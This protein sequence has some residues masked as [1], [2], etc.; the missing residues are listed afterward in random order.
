MYGDRKSFGVFFC[1]RQIL[2]HNTL[3]QH[4]LCNTKNTNTMISSSRRLPVASIFQMCAIAVHPNLDLNLCNTS[5]Q[6][7]YL[8]LMYSLFYLLLFCRPLTGALTDK[9]HVFIEYLC[10]FFCH[11]I[12]STHT[13]P[14]YLSM[15]FLLMLPKSSSH[16]GMI[17]D[18]GG[19]VPLRHV[20]NVVVGGTEAQG[21]EG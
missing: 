8:K 12:K 20:H 21:T 17:L 14:S 4:T 18:E 13:D 19:G 9:R 15:V 10:F 7:F 2:H 3:P 16:F 11:C 6:F 1:S 5:M